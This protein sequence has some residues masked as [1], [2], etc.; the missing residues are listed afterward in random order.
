MAAGV[1]CVDSQ[2]DPLSVAFSRNFCFGRW[3]PASRVAFE[4]TSPSKRR[5]PTAMNARSN[6]S[7]SS[8]F[9]ARS[10]KSGRRRSAPRPKSQ[11][12]HTLAL[13]SHAAQAAVGC[14][15]GGFLTDFDHY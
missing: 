12:E 5:M 4:S 11:L 3:E 14:F 8:S 9:I 2:K 15:A 6:A 1:R 7:K 13:G 10:E